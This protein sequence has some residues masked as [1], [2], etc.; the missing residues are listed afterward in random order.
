MGE[1]VW[2]KLTEAER[3]RVLK[4]YV[5]SLDTRGLSSTEEVIMRFKRSRG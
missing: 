4:A 3:A 5:S 1:G 2:T